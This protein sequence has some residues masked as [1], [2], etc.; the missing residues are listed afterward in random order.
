MSIN[1][2]NDEELADMIWHDTRPSIF[3]DFL[4]DELM[5]PVPSLSVAD[6]FGLFSVFTE[7]K[8]VTC[9]QSCI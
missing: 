1:I 8:S 5:I 4:N 9:V 7:R 2:F 3:K 6:N